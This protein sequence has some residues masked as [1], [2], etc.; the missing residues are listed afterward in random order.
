[1]SFSFIISCKNLFSA[2]I[3]SGNECEVIFPRIRFL[4][5]ILFFDCD[6]SDIV[7]VGRRAA[8]RLYSARILFPLV[9]AMI[10]AVVWE[11]VYAL[12]LIL[13]FRQLC[14]IVSFISL[15]P[16]LPTDLNKLLGLLRPDG[17][18]AKKSVTFLRKR[19]LIELFNVKSGKTGQN[20]YLVMSIL[21]IVWLFLFYTFFW[22]II[23]SG[24]LSLLSDLS[25]G[26]FGFTV[27][28][29][30]YISFILLPAL[31]LLITSILIGL[32]NVGSVIRTPVHRMTKVALEINKK[33]VPNK[34]QVIQFL[35][36]IPLFS[37]LGENDL[38]KLCEYLHCI[39]VRAGRNIIIQGE[40]GD[41]FY[42][43]VSGNVQV[44]REN[45]DSSERIIDTLGTGDSFGEIALIEHVPRTATIRTI[46]AVTVLKLDKKY[47]E[48]F[49]LEGGSG[50]DTITDLIRISK[51]LMGTGIFSYLN[52]RQISSLVH[53]LK[54]QT[55]NKGES[56]FQQGDTGDRFYI[57]KEGEVQVQ[58]TKDSKV[59][60]EK[61]IGSGGFFGE[62]ALIK[63][64]PRT[65]S[66]VSKSATMLLYLT[67]QD[68]YHVIKDNLLAG[69]QF[70]ALAE[71]RIAR[72]GEEVVKAC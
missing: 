65:A 40:K 32:F 45:A 28:I 26:P 34:E 56:V 29:Y 18:D 5:G 53:T 71:N 20:Y 12:P 27:L 54:K 35:Q 55:F 44:I 50:K 11:F 25:A 6:L 41:A 67:K 7:K 48:Q 70:D 19:F 47:F 62:I 72:L 10:A 49:I 16:L 46:N 60:M 14:I 57:V 33:S 42:T 59:T 22:D 69:I 15:S 63:N 58:H 68:F 23:R 43:I 38:H 66:V 37:T 24:I 17:G 13:L 51:M 21:S 1:V 4:W 30:T 3:L 52:P 61:T 36:E 39:K 8:V 2:Y 64:V 31:L 9:L